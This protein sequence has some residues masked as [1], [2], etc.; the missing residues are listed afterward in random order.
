MLS[1]K[2]I[3]KNYIINILFCLIPITYIAGNLVLNIN[4]LIFFMFFFGSFQLKIF[5]FKFNNIDKFV[6]IFFFICFDKRYN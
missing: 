4:I 5:Q 1:Q 6:L 3:S 2:P